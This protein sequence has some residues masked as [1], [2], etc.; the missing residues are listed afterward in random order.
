MDAATAD[1]KNLIARI[2]IIFGKDT[3]D[4]GVD[5]EGKLPDII[6][7]YLKIGKAASEAKE[8]KDIERLLRSVYSNISPFDD[9]DVK[10]ACLEKKLNFDHE[11][12]EFYPF[13]FVVA[14]SGAGKTQLP[15]SMKHPVLYFLHES[16]LIAQEQK[17]QETGAERE[18]SAQPIYNPF[19]A[20]SQKLRECIDKDYMVYTSQG[21]GKPLRT[22]F[23]L[24]SDK[25]KLFTIGFIVTLCK[26]ILKMREE[27]K[28]NE[29]WIVL[30]LGIKNTEFEEYD[31]L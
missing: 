16:F 21:H 22:F 29:H 2:D 19:V 23:S 26:S 30:Q 31:N 15:F 9:L 10:M 14:S 17:N 3:M 1:I 7:N 8:I 18:P 4:S 12:S 5:I 20:L 6:E 28:H 24:I 13:I 11:G 25:V 27:G